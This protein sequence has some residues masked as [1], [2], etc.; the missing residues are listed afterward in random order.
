MLTANVVLLSVL[1]LLAIAKQYFAHR[2]YHRSAAACAGGEA[3]IAAAFIF[4]GLTPLVRV[5]GLLLAII[6]VHSTIGHLGR[7]FDSEK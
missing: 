3:I 6:E 2:R 5:A 4:V 1:I 7:A